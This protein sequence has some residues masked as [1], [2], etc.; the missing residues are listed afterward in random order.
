MV[1]PLYGRSYKLGSM[2][3]E[4]E[5]NLANDYSALY[6]H[7]Y[8]GL[9]YRP[10]N[11]VPYPAGVRALAGMY[12]NDR[13]KVKAQL[14]VLETDTRHPEIYTDRILKLLSATK[15]QTEGFM[16]VPC[17]DMTM[18]RSKPEKIPKALSIPDEEAGVVELDS[19]TGGE[20]VPAW[21]WHYTGALPQ[22]IIYKTSRQIMDPVAYVDLMQTYSMLLSKLYNMS[23]GPMGASWS[24]TLLARLMAQ[25]VPKIEADMVNKTGKELLDS[26]ATDVFQALSLLL[27]SEAAIGALAWCVLEDPVFTGVTGDVIGGSGTLLPGNIQSQY[28]ST[29]GDDLVAIQD[30]FADMTKGVD[31]FKTAYAAAEKAGRIAH[32]PTGIL[33][34]HQF[35]AALRAVRQNIFSAKEKLVLNWNGPLTE[36]AGA[37]RTIDALTRVMD[38]LP[39]LASMEWAPRPNMFTVTGMGGFSA[40]S[41]QLMRTRIHYDRVAVRRP[42]AITVLDGEEAGYTLIGGKQ[43]SAYLPV[44]VSKPNRA[45]CADSAWSANVSHEATAIEHTRT[46]LGVDDAEFERFMATMKTRTGRGLRV[47]TG[48]TLGHGQIAYLPLTPAA[49]QT[50]PTFNLIE[51]AGV[52]DLV[53]QPDAFAYKGTVV[54][55]PTVQEGKFSNTDMLAPATLQNVHYR[56]KSPAAE[57]AVRWRIE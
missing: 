22:Y 29:L 16:L 33:W 46:I 19:E 37:I 35:R 27:T 20:S 4:P 56:T 45:E 28:G 52:V 13:M 38:E 5:M 31:I 23:V 43:M 1:E 32:Y 48:E 34:T 2:V 57:M 39:Q 18:H 25:V 10:Q 49:M 8:F 24:R 14:E 40:Y 53:E 26:P 54:L 30:R 47:M 12:V 55:P 9:A 50:V 41:A 51:P 21:D 7:S 44:Y 11:F 6:M 15:M 3:E 36:F 42:N 17:T